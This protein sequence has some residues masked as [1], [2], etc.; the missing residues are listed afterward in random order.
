MRELNQ[1]IRA[2]VRCCPTAF[3]LLGSSQPLCFTAGV[4]LMGAAHGALTIKGAHL[5]SHGSL[6]GS[7]AGADFWAS[8]F[9]EV[10]WAAH[11]DYLDHHWRQCR[12]RKRLYGFD[13]Y[14]QNG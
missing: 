2:N 8:F 14:L 10:R 13:M 7:Q 1:P 6:S 9:I 11:T 4:L 5:A 12:C 3:L